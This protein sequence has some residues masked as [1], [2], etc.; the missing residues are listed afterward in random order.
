M[1]YKKIITCLVL[2]VLMVACTNGES[3]ES[4]GF[5]PEEIQQLKDAGVEDEANACANK[6]AL[7]TVLKGD[8]KSDKMNTYCNISE[9]ITKYDGLDLMVTAGFDIEKIEQYLSIGYYRQENINRYITYDAKG[10]D[11]KDVI[12][13]VNIGLDQPYYEN[14]DTIKD[15]DSIALLV[16]KYHKLP[17]HYVPK[18]LVETPSPCT[19]GKD[20][21]CSTNNPQMVVQVVGEQFAQMVE[22]GEKEGIKLKSIASYRDYAYQLNLYTYWLGQSGIEY[23]DA[24]YARAGQSEHNSGLAIDVTFENENFNEIENSVHYP[25]LLEHMA[26]YGFILRYPKDKEDI[27]GFGY[28]S[29]HLRYVGEEIAKY[30]M[31]HNL[32][33]DEYYAQLEV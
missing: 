5:Q 14:V 6:E 17:E 11:V 26:S 4:A 10:K 30:I 27:T 7:K 21:S 19:I 29:W 1:Q 33:L 2:S 3:L 12:T 20:Y 22:A 18:N 15:T 16:N 25:W 13:N 32:T 28:E 23:A 31:E 24:Y 8:F 9:E